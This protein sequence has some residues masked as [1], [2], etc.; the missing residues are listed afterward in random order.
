MTEEKI[1]ELVD[2]ALAENPSLFLVSLTILPSNKI[3]IIVD[4]DAGVPLSE[5]VRI[6]RAVE[7]NLDRET[8]DFSLEVSTPDITQPLTLNR[9]YKKNIGKTLKI[10]T[11]EKNYEAVLTAVQTDAITLQW[12]EKE[13][14]P[15]GKGKV[16]VTKTA[17][18]NFND[19]KQAKVKLVF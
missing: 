7:H 1:L 14:K 4:G 8:E 15:I 19:I 9:Q 12:E 2:I 5:C 16:V 18:V 17:T 3:N 6:S 10:K 13:K 11:E